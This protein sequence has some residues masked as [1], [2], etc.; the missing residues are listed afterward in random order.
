[1]EE[2]LN[3]LSKAH[4]SS[5]RLKQQAQGPQGEGKLI[6]IYGNKTRDKLGIRG[7]GKARKVMNMS[8]ERRHKNNCFIVSILS[9]IFKSLG[10]ISS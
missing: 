8:Y 7:S 6:Y 3:Q 9:W 10:Q 1:M 2:P 4:N 5:Q